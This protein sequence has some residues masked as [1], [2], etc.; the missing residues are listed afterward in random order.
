MAPL[1]NVPF[2]KIPFFKVPFPHPLSKPP[3]HP[4]GSKWD[5]AIDYLEQQDGKGA[6]RVSESD[7]RKRNDLK[8][9]LQ[10]RANNRNVSVEVH[11][12]GIAVYA[13]MRTGKPVPND[14]LEPNPTRKSV[15]FAGQFINLTKLSKSSGYGVAFLSR[16]FSDER[17]PSLK[18][19]IKIAKSLDMGLDWF[20][21]GLDAN[22]QHPE[23]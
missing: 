4:T 22:R 9:T 8:A 17:E 20:V 10:T 5:G 11:D 7:E 6:V 18:A 16:I 21:R 2:D 19:A 12:D 3:V 15:L 13:W 14:C 23:A 1:R